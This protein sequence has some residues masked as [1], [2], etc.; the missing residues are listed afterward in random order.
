MKIHFTCPE[1]SQLRGSPESQ[2]EDKTVTSTGWL[3]SSRERYSHGSGKGGCVLLIF[4]VSALKIYLI[5]A[6]F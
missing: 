4:S 5:L 2:P 3:E 6:S 1:E